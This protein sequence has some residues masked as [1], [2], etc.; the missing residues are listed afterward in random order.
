MIYCEAGDNVTVGM[1]SD[2]GS[3]AV[4][5]HGYTEDKEHCS[6]NQLELPL[7]EYNDAHVEI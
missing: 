6:P 1:V 2:R 4:D 3:L 7:V 5:I